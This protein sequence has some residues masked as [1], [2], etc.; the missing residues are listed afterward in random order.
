MSEIS[1]HSPCNPDP[2][3]ESHDDIIIFAKGG[4][5]FRDSWEKNLRWYQE[6][7]GDPVNVIYALVD[8]R[9]WKGHFRGE[10][11]IRE[12]KGGIDG[13]D[14]KAVPTMPALTD[15]SSLGA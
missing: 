6:N 4:Y 8:G 2:L 12:E 9:G 13:I 10:K 11:K 1:A 14:G 7:E 15:F 5:C 3:P